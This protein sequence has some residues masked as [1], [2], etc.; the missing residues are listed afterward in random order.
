VC[1]Q[2]PYCIDSGCTSHCSPVQSDFINLMPIPHRVVCGMNGRAIP[3]IGIGTIKLRCRKGRRI[4]LKNALLVPDAILC[5]ISIGKLADDALTTTFEG[6]IC[7]ICK[8][9]GKT[10]AD[11]T[12]K[13]QGLYYLAG[14]DPKSD[15]WAFISHASPDLA[16][17]H[18]CLGHINYTSII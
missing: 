13:G 6:S 18:I 8:S 16:N 4:V 14:S 7:H 10:I 11:G 3:A 1:T 15:E 12:R 5:L 17:W 2:L 9:S